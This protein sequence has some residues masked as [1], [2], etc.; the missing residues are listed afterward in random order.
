MLGGLSAMF[1]KYALPIVFAVGLTVGGGTSYLIQS[2]RVQGAKKDVAE[3]QTALANQLVAASEAAIKARADA[4]AEIEAE[5]S[6][7]DSDI[8]RGQ[9]A[10]ASEAAKLRRQLSE[11]S[12]QADYACL[13]V[14]LPSALLDGLRR[15]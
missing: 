11:L 6:R 14:P 9:S 2:G 7:I 5:R 1:A 13:A 3:C 12:L 8:S 10:V 15:P 4:D